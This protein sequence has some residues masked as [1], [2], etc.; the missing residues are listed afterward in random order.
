MKS[1]SKLENI[2]M[3]LSES[4]KNSR[5]KKEEKVINKIKVD[6]GQFYKYAKHLLKREMT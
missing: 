2:E 5:I 6:S 3:N 4:L 1:L